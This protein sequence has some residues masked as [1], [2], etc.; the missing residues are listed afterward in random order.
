ML[1]KIRTPTLQE[2]SPL[3]GFGKPGSH[4]GAHMEKTNGGLHELMVV[5]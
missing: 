4:G 1:H 3:A 5:S 2:D